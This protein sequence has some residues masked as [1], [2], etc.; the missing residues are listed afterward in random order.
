MPAQVGHRDSASLR[1]GLNDR[2]Q[3][4]WRGPTVAVRTEGGFPGTAGA[5]RV[6]A[7][8]A[9]PMAAHTT[10]VPAA[11]LTREPTAACFRK[12]LRVALWD[13][14]GLRW[15]R[16]YPTCQTTNSGRRG[17]ARSR[18]APRPRVAA[19]SPGRPQEQEHPRPPC[20]THSHRPG[21]P[22]PRWD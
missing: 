19:L 13:M 10:A 17:A 2:V 18:I 14:A 20:P 3:A 4:P 8:A 22:D 11:S 12:S 7:R 6:A 5:W 16:C 15:P 1:K 21:A 9:T